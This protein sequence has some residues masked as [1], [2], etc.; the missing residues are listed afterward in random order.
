MLTT[1]V[2]LL[3]HGLIHL[4]GF[5]KA[6]GLASLR[7]LPIAISRPAGAAWLA[8]AILC[9]V[10]AIAILGAA[11]WWWA[12]TLA[13]A[14][15]SQALVIS[16]W[17][18]AK[19]GTAVNLV[20]LA[21]AVYGLFSVG[22]ASLR[23]EYEAATRSPA[24]PAGAPR[25]VTEEDV[26]AL[27]A[28]VARYLRFVG[29]VG[30]PRIG[31]FRVRFT[32]KIRKGPG[33]PWMPFAAEQRSVVAG[34]R[35]ARHFFME[36]R[37]MG[38]PVDGYHRFADGAASMRV[39]ALSMITMV[40]ARGPAFTATEAVTLFNDLCVMAPAALVGAPVEWEAVDDRTVRGTYRVAGA[41]VRATLLFGDDGALVDFQSDDRP[42]LE[43][44]G[45]TF[46]PQRW[47]TPLRAYRRFG[48]ARL[49]G[50]ADLEYA[51]SS[52]KYAY[53]VFELTDVV[54]EP[55]S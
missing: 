17:A 8:A 23:A 54:Y 31:A 2:L 37:M 27:P 12:I 53:G 55:A 14:V 25:P 44:D 51:P 26:A 43:A 11:R 46:T 42:A 19:A 49:A 50:E 4:L 29:A 32:G 22:P 7:G 45:K 18:E 39:R 35:P 47:S 13:A 16:A 48:P 34:P 41:A 10:A 20:A 1:A 9:V 6:F 21:V 15:L 38:L 30:Q 33:A 24:P 3:V 36:A 40:D 28:P 52:G 5:V